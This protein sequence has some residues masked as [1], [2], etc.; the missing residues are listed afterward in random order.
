MSEAVRQLAGPEVRTC[1]AEVLL[2]CADNRGSEARHSLKQM[3][4]STGV[5]GKLEGVKRR[6]KKRAQAS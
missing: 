5:K 4:S 1:T 2:P 3:N 6:V